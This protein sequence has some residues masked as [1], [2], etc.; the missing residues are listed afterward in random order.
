MSWALAYLGTLSQALSSWVPSRTLYIISEVIVREPLSFMPSTLTFFHSV[1]IPLVK[2]LTIYTL[3][4]S[5]V[6]QSISIAFTS[7]GLEYTVGIKSLIIIF[8][9]VF[10]IPSL[11]PFWGVYSNDPGKNANSDQ[12]EKL[13][14]SLSSYL[15]LYPSL[16]NFV[17]NKGFFTSN[18]TIQLVGLFESLKS[19][20]TNSISTS[21]LFPSDSTTLPLITIGG[22]TFWAVNVNTSSSW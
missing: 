16:P 13:E 4:L 10:A 6:F 1:S 21:A 20:S 12:G 8:L 15:Y 17:S 9:A 5:V 14:H 19:E 18:V 7:K 3:A 11:N 22:S 2:V